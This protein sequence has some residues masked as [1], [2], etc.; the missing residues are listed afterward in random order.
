MISLRINKNCTSTT[1]F[2]HFKPN[3][4]VKKIFE[5]PSRRTSKERYTF[6][7]LQQYTVT[8]IL[9]SNSFLVNI[10]LV[11]LMFNSSCLEFGVYRYLANLN[12]CC[13][14][15]I[16]KENFF[17]CWGLTMSVTVKS[18][19]F[20]KNMFFKSPIKKLWSNWITTVSFNLSNEARLLVHNHGPSVCR[21][22]DH[23]LEYT[24]FLSSLLE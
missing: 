3:K 4:I 20:F 10:M 12:L 2:F 6:T 7:Q 18:L 14:F 5:L 23:S 8:S 19:N 16:T 9:H 24:T 21:A 13:R 11:Y 1:F 22:N 15:S 17:V